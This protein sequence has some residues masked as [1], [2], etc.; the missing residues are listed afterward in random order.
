MSLEAV[1]LAVWI[2]KEYVKRHQYAGA[3]LAL[4]ASFLLALTV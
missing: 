1:F 2:K 4:A 3:F